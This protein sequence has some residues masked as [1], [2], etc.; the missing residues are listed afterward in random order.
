MRL[1]EVY[2]CFKDRADFYWIYVR[3]AHPS[4]GF[5]PA[6]HVSIE[7][8]TTFG[9]RTQV[10]STCSADLKLTIPVLVDDMEDTVAKAYNALPDRLFILN[11]EGTI[12]YRGDRGPRGF[13]VDEMEQALAKLVPASSVAQ[14]SASK[15]NKNPRSTRR[16]P[17]LRR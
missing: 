9:R 16:P 10:A 4:D 17:K 15:G 12:A 5:R 11:S 7:Q 1:Q 13:K 6:R 8:P 14:S 2:D 3:E